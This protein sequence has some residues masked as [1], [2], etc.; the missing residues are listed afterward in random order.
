M[1]PIPM[2]TSEGIFYKNCNDELKFLQ[3]GNFYRDWENA[4]NF[5]AEMHAATNTRFS[6][7]GIPF[8]ECVTIKRPTDEIVELNYVVYYKSDGVWFQETKPGLIFAEAVPEKI[9]AKAD[10]AEKEV[11]IT[12]YIENEWEASK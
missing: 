3:G 2:I 5:F 12:D 8:A 6:G 10:G 1:I 4:L 7:T 9:L 11:D